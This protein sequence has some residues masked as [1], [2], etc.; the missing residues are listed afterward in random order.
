MKC[1]GSKPAYIRLAKEYLRIQRNPLPFVTLRP[2]EHNLLEWHF[3]LE[4]IPES[5]FAG[6]YYHG[7]LEFPA[8]YP[9]KPPS[10]HMITPNGRFEPGKICL[11][12][13][14][15]HQKDWHPFWDVATIACALAS[16]MLSDEPTTGSIQTLDKD[17]RLLA[18]CSTD[19][20]SKNPIFREV[21]PEFCKSENNKESNPVLV[22]PPSRET[23]KNE[24]SYVEQGLKELGETTTAGQWWIWVIF[25]MILAK[26]LEKYSS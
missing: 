8:E 10:I 11:S 21:F 13:S 5:P 9:Y 12:A 17:K 7:K 26:I 18:E 19:F 24:K 3:I 1:A 22:H 2:L 15:F 4:G 20:N 25:F 14:S 16:F 6:G 23:H